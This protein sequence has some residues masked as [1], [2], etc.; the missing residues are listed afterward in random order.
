MGGGLHCARV[1]EE[2]AALPAHLP[3]W[4]P[5]LCCA[6]AP[7]TPLLVSVHLSIRCSC[8]RAPSC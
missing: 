8:W 5:L 1:G 6:G 4:L 7:P 2:L 3:G